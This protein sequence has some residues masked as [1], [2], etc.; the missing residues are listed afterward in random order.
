[1]N[2][3]RYENVDMFKYLGLLIT[4]TN[5]VTAEIKARIFAGN[6]LQCTGSFT[7]G[8]YVTVINSS[9]TDCNLWCLSWTL[10]NKMERL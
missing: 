1:M 6:M 5:D 8:R 7:G 9:K 2:G 3:Q 4:N 10:T